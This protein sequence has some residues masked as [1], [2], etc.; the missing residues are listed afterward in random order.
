MINIPRGLRDF[1]LAIM[2]FQISASL[3]EG[4][5][6]VK[7]KSLGA[8]SRSMSSK[9]PKTDASLS[10]PT[11]LKLNAVR[12]HKPNYSPYRFFVDLMTF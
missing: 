2:L 8:H 1:T 7:G 11:S 6:G 12:Y 10:Y 5:S 3:G 9:T 4:R